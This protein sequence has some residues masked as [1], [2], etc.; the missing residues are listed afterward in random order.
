MKILV[1]GSNDVG[2]A[3]ALR[4]L[5]AGQTVILHD[6]PRPSAT[7]RGMAFADAFFDDQ[8]TLEGVTAR[9][10]NLPALKNFPRDFLPVCAADFS[11]LWAAFAPEILVDARMKKHEQPEN[12]IHLAAL[13]IGLGPGFIAGETVH[14][15]V[16]TGWGDA[17]GQVIRLGAAR[18]LAG[19]PNPIDGHAR[20][21]YGYAPCEG[22]F[23][24]ALAIGARVTAGQP[25][26]QIGETPLFAPLSGVLRGLTHD[27]APVKFKT[28][29]IEVDPR[30]DPALVFGVGQRPAKIA[31]GVL[32]AIQLWMTGN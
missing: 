23:T 29:V 26:A 24:T 7:R 6:A 17:L 19:E 32:A 15:V 21:R 25:V 18:A 31:A 27:G 1:R 28:K 10:I 11:A 8:S 12:Q 3:L 4:L 9:R 2:S 20:D 22:I 14:L 16:E 30:G 13:T 5:Q